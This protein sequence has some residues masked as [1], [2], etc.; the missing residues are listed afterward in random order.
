MTAATID[1]DALRD[2]RMNA[3]KFS[4]DGRRLGKMRWAFRETGVWMF[5]FAPFEPA[6]MEQA[7]EAKLLQVSREPHVAHAFWICTA[8][9]QD[10]WRQLRGVPGLIPVIRVQPEIREGVMGLTAAALVPRKRMTPA[11]ADVLQGLATPGRVWQWQAW[12]AKQVDAHP[13][14]RPTLSGTA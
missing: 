14:L 6:E 4:P 12:A 3:R 9:R 13:P 5:P 7:A 10:L 2:A 1:L 8:V 11:I